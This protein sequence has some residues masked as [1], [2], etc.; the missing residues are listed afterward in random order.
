LGQRDPALL[1]NTIILDDSYEWWK[2]D[3]DSYT[4]MLFS[5]RFLVWRSYKCVEERIKTPYYLSDRVTLDSK[6]KQ[7]FLVTGVEAGGRRRLHP[8][9]L[10]GT[11][12]GSIPRT[13]HQKRAVLCEPCA[14]G[15]VHKGDLQAHPERVL[16]AADVHEG[17]RPD[18]QGTAQITENPSLRDWTAGFL[19][20][21][22]L[23]TVELP[24]G[25]KISKSCF[26]VV[27]NFEWTEPNQFRDRF[28]DERHMDRCFKIE[29][30]FDTF[31]FVKLKE[32]SYYNYF[33]PVN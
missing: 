2:S 30:I 18:H 29:L 32:P 8:T 3:A 27:D 25:G 16:P 28:W 19:R 9:E 4:S 31:F 14:L 10:L 22:D 24:P 15:A 7:A 1:Q 26:V 11:H 23:K 20:S 12:P 21:L 33:R 6:Y 5:K 17:S 13:F